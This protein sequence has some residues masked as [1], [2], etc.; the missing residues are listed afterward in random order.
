[1]KILVAEDN[2]DDVVLLTHALK[3]ANLTSTS[4]LTAVA[5]GLQALAY[6]NGEDPYA[7]R[8]VHPFPDILLLDLNM[9]RM[10]GFEVL[11]RVRADE[12]CSRL[13]VHV[14]TASARDADV[15][16]AYELHANSYTIKPTRLDQLVGFLVAL[17]QWHA[18]VT[19][20]S[21]PDPSKCAC[22]AA[23]TQEPI[24]T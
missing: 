2:P 15:Q 20:A 17:H 16:R 19:L 5:D 23:G 9:P 4:S 3:K 6:L 18:F 1:M 21:P 12:H 13:M 14:L 10:N 22:V 8:A 7:D 24:H 11:E